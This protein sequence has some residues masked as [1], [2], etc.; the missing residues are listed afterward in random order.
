LSFDSSRRQL[1]LSW[2]EALGVYLLLKRNEAGLDENMC[3]LLRRLEQ[4]LYRQLTIE[5]LEN[6]EGL[7]GGKV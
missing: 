3:R 1:S 6:L 2:Q 5:E 7:Y 4:E